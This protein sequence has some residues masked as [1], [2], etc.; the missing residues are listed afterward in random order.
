MKI[1]FSSLCI[2]IASAVTFENAFAICDAELTNL[3]Q[4]NRAHYDLQNMAESKK[5]ELAKTAMEYHHRDMPDRIRRFDSG[6]LKQEIQIEVENNVLIRKELA[7][8]K[9]RPAYDGKALAI[10]YKN[11]ELA[12]SLWRLC[13]Y[14]SS[15]S[16]RSGITSQQPQTETS[17]VQQP[18]AGSPPQS[19]RDCF[20]RHDYLEKGLPAKEQLERL[21]VHLACVSEWQKISKSNQA[22]GAAVSNSAQEPQPQAIVTQSQNRARESQQRGDADAQRR[23]RRVHDPAAEAHDCIRPIFTGLFGSFENS[24]NYP[25]YY[26]Y[27]AYRPKSDS[28]LT[29]LDCEK[30][31]FGSW[32]VGP[33][34]QSAA[35]TK[36][37]ESIHWFACKNPAWAVDKSFDG[38]QIQGRCRVIGAN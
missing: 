30:Q 6:R 31:Q 22:A 13:W 21:K 10:A 20:T 29:T 8:V 11:A 12:G 5:Q 17:P 36:G 15:Q 18:Y 34:R 32:E 3:I 23:G 7:E 24:C 37:A 1:R 33:N 9:A 16:G 28:W 27:C 38:G 19:F 4:A 35:H 25:V 26:S 14:E 2:L